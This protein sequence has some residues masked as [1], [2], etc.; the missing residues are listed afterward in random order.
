MV[1]AEN[2]ESVRRDLMEE[3]EAN[4]RNWV[5]SSFVGSMSMAEFA[6]YKEVNC[7]LSLASSS[8]RAALEALEISPAACVQGTFTEGGWGASRRRF[9]KDSPRVMAVNAIA[10]SR[11]PLFEVWGRNAIAPEEYRSE[12][13][14]GERQR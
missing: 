7:G 14:V 10:S 2:I 3:V 5:E 6:L 8:A 11:V 4:L 12:W 9:D 13:P 1:R